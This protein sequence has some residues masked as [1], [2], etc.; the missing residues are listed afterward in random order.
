MTKGDN[1]MENKNHPQK[2]SRITVEP[3][4]DTKDIGSIKKLLSNNPRDLLLFCLGIN[5]GFRCGDLLKIRVRNLKKL[6][7]GETFTITEQKTGKSNI[8]MINKSCHKVMKD[9]LDK[10][11]PDDNDYLFQ[12]RKGI[13][14]P[15]SVSSV[16]GMV[17]EWCSSIHLKGNYGT[18]SLRKTFGYIQR[19]KYGIG[20]EILCKRFN[21]SSP[22][23]TMRYLG[24]ED[25][26][27]NGILMNE[28]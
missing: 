5:N 10:V 17:K 16:N 19:T 24:I 3:I 1:N 9:Y 23:I 8:L 22:S 13:N 11:K 20:W 6:K 2:G 12:S 7:P 14:Q 26:E 28:I 27:V 21:H 18:H 15:L 4:R 25:K